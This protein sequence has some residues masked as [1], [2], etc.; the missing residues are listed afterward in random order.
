MSRTRTRRP[1]SRSFIGFST[2]FPPDA[3]SLPGG[4]ATGGAQP[5]E[6]KAGRPDTTRDGTNGSG[7]IGWYGPHPPQGDP[8]HHYHFEVFALD[9]MLPVPPGATRDAV[10]AAMAGHVV[11]KGE[12]VATYAER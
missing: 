4:K 7:T 6:A 12:F 11:A 8:P 9:R 3:H 1:R 5:R 10:E 2:T